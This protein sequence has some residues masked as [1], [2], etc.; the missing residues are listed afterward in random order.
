MINPLAS[1]GSSPL[2]VGKVAAVAR[3][4]PVKASAKAEAAVAPTPAADLAAAGPPVDQ[5]KVDRIK[6]G[7]ANGSYKPDH[8]SIARRMVDQDLPA[9]Q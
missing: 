5:S 4:A 1:P 8:D 7:I 6:A 3:T 2:K 9:G